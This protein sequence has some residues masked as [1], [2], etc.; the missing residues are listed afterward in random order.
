MDDYRETEKSVSD[1]LVICPKCGSKN[2][3]YQICHY[4]EIDANTHKI[5]GMDDGNRMDGYTCIEC[6][7][8]FR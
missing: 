3:I 1:K 8:D 6:G 5:R 4:Q 7:E 2:V